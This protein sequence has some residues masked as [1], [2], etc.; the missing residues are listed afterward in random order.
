MVDLMDPTITLAP[1]APKG[2][3][4]ITVTATDEV[5]VF[6]TN[7]ITVFVTTTFQTTT[8]IFDTSF[9]HVTH[10]VTNNSTLTTPVTVMQTQTLTPTPVTVTQTQTLTPTSVRPTTTS[11]PPPICPALSTQ[12]AREKHVDP[13]QIL[14]IVFGVFILFLLALMCFLVR[15]F[16][17]MY[18]AERVMRKQIQTEGT[19]LPSKKVAVSEGEMHVV[20]EE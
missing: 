4:L 17:K 16:Y 7:E 11:P 15:R 2:P 8:S 20:G 10:T 18:R 14:S 9:I 6:I 5:T 12:V 13:F 1:R 19:E 3:K